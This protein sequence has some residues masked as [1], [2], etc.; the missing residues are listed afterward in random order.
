MAVAQ[1]RCVGCGAV[2]PKA[3]L[4]RVVLAAGGVQA[5]PGQRRP[6]RGA[7]VC[8]RAC[9]E[10]ALARNAFARSFRAAVPVDPDLLDSL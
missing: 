4:R 10:R 6:G 5:D 2:R 7:Y 1:R 8:D 9:A 3:E